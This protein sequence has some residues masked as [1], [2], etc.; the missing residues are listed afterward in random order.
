MKHWLSTAS[1][2]LYY[3]YHYYYYY[4]I[5]LLYSALLYYTRGSPRIISVTIGRAFAVLS[6]A[7]VEA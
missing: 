3:Y 1:P 6:D 5:T 7:Y 2:R 4:T